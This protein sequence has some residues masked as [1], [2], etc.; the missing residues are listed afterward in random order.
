MKSR[1]GIDRL[2]A[3]IQRF[4]RIDA[5]V[6]ELASI[7]RSKAAIPDSVYSERSRHYDEE[8]TMIAEAFVEGVLGARVRYLKKIN[9]MRTIAGLRGVG[10]NRCAP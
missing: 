9:S 3:S 8:K 6:Q 4:A 2:D 1:A 5:R 10:Y 7:L